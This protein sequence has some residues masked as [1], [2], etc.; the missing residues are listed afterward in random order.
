MFNTDFIHQLF[1][2]SA[3]IAII[4]MIQA[5]NTKYFAYILRHIERYISKHRRAFRQ[6]CQI[7]ATILSYN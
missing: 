2:E 5:Q 4:P 1:L 6:L 7:Q 3:I